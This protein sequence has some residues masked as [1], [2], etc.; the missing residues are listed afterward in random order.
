MLVHH[1]YPMNIPWT[2]E[3]GLP[4]ESWRRLQRSS[5]SKAPFAGQRCHEPPLGSIHWE[6]WCGCYEHGHFL[7][8]ASKPWLSHLYLLY[9][10]IYIYGFEAMNMGGSK[11]L[12]LWIVFFQLENLQTMR[13][14]DFD[15]GKAFLASGSPY[16]APRMQLVR[17]Q[18]LLSGAWLPRPAQIHPLWESLGDLGPK[19]ISR[20]VFLVY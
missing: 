14:N 9:I 17:V 3:I 8:L 5:A 10:S 11:H 2:A 16:H 13:Q 7:E 18:G 1:Q 4:W 12:K 15:P 20:I 19:I 6:V